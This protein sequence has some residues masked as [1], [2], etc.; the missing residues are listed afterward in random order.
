M[1]NKKEW[2]LF[3][4]RKELEPLTFS[5][6]K[7]QQDVV[8]ETIDAIK[9]GHKIIFIKGKCGTGKSAIALNLAKQLGRTSVVVPV[10]ALQKQYENDYTKEKYLIKDGKKLKISTITGR[11]NHSCPFIKENPE[12]FEQKEKNSTLFIFDKQEKTGKKD[13]TCNNSKLPC[14]IKLKKRNL[15]QLKKYI[16]NNPRVKSSFLTLRNI[17]RMSVAPVCPYWSPMVPKQVKLNLEADKKN[18]LGLKNTEYT[19]YKRKKGCSYYDQYIAYLNSDVL[20]FNS[21]KYI[22]ETIMNRKPFT[23]LEVIDECDEF[24]D[25]F[26]NEKKINLNRLA[27]SLTSVFPDS[28]E[29]EETVNLIRKKVNEI[30]SNKKIKKYIKQEKIFKLEKT[31]ILSMLEDFLQSDFVEEVEDEE[32]YCFHVDEVAR[33][34]QE[35]FEETYCTFYNKDKDLMLRI[36]SI[37]LEKMFK[38]LL[39]KNKVLVLMSGTIHS[40]KVLKDI[41]GLENFKII[42]AE[43]KMP[44]NLEKVKTG[45]EVNCKYKNF[46]NKKVTRKQYLEALQKSI[47]QA[48]KPVLIHV[49]SFKDLPSEKEKE[50]YQLDLMSREKLFKK[51]ENAEEMVKMFKQ[52]KLKVLYTTKCNRGADFPGETCKSIVLTKYPYPHIRSLFWR[53]LRKQKPEH[54]KEFYL[55]KAGREFLQRIYRGLRSEQDTI[56]LLSPDI[57]VFYNI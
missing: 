3:E 2:S 10:K 40:E 50:K 17:R 28:P 37:N 42:E 9:Q 26:A 49:N 4:D 39:E 19:V 25:S 15:K 47:N 5:N 11:Q 34:F 13:F 44:G 35:L 20:I 8:E 14:K 1:A 54:F 30:L 23:E 33:M 12:Y 45:L 6:G 27:F 21:H 24:L 55:D 29:T 46:I 16:K 18:Y 38:Q 52:G 51:Q 31:P 48:E 41:F 53:I 36:I 22:L 57:R 43:T 56:T 32:S 7:N